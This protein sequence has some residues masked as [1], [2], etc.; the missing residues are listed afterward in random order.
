MTWM[1]AQ[2]RSDTPF[3][4]EEVVEGTLAPLGWRAEGKA[5]VKVIAKG[6]VLADEV[7]Y[8]KTAITLGLIDSAPELPAKSSEELRKVMAESGRIPLK[9]TLI[10][11]PP[12]L[13]RQ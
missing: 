5:T 13:L 2:E 10:L 8:G 3:L 1:L 9:A 6:G 7:G 12:H 4:E 11:A